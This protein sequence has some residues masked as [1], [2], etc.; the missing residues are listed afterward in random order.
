MW[1]VW[2]RQNPDKE[3]LVEKAA[4]ILTTLNGAY[5]QRFGEDAQLSDQEVQE[6][7]RQL[8]QAIQ[9]TGDSR[10]RWFSFTPVR[11]GM[12][13]S[14]LVLLGVFGWYTFRDGRSNQGV[15]HEEFVTNAASSLPA[16]INTTNQPLP[17]DLPDRSTVLLYPKSRIS[18]DKRFSGTK[19]E[20][21]LVGKAYFNVTR[22]PS[23]PFYVYSNGLVTKV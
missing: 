23:R 2:L 19:R 11:Y 10:V 14:L 13:A 9:E 7:I 15:S 20:V 22:H 3:E 16:V 12:A 17:I 1:I 4:Y 6:E 18:F 21:Y 8:H 5:E